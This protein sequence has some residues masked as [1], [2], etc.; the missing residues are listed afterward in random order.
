MSSSSQHQ[1]FNNKRDDLVTGIKHAVNSVADKCLTKRLIS[2]DTYDEVTQSEKEN[3]QKARQLLRNISTGIQKDP[4]SLDIF[5]KL[6]NETDCKDVAENLQKEWRDLENRLT[7]QQPE[8]NDGEP[9][10]TTGSMMSALRS[11]QPELRKRMG[12]QVNS[13]AQGQGQL[14]LFSSSSG[15]EMKPCAVLNTPP[16]YTESLV[17]G[18]DYSQSKSAASKEEDN[19]AIQQIC[20]DDEN[21]QIQINGLS[22]QIKENDTEKSKLCQRND[23]LELQIKEL[24][25]RLS[26]EEKKRYREEK[27]RRE[28]EKLT[29]DLTEKNVGMFKEI[30]QLYNEK[31]EI[32]LKLDKLEK[33]N[34]D[35]LKEI[36]E[37]QEFRKS[38]KEESLKEKLEMKDEI[39]Q[40]YQ[41]KI[42]DVKKKHWRNLKKEELTSRILYEIQNHRIF[43]IKQCFVVTIIVIVIVISFL[44]FF[45][46]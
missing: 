22:A 36:K 35:L 26:F 17:V 23:E 11:Q 4:S 41:R 6:L 42:D 13:I 27:M 33:T 15:K 45:L 16:Q 38:L 20:F 3:G 1:A 43:K 12:H 39:K 19:T 21:M 34:D 29:S 40:D 2:E 46:S 32:Q 44:V 18:I 30:E 37:L 10:S 8:E 5:I 14:G 28:S 25:N 31:K 9:D 7:I 24:Q